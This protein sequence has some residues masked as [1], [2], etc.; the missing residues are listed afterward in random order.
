MG[1]LN[2][3]MKALV[4]SLGWFLWHAGGSG[5]HLVLGPSPPELSVVPRTGPRAEEG[6]LGP[7]TATGSQVPGH[8][9]AS[10][11]PLP[12]SGWALSASCVPDIV[13]W[14]TAAVPSSGE[15]GAPLC[16]SFP[17]PWPR[18]ILQDKVALGSPPAG[19]SPAAPLRQATLLP[20]TFLVHAGVLSSATRSMEAT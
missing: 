2:L 4:Q 13:G 12:F 11:S 18:L 1:R 19:T 15:P 3:E 20:A 6:F 8:H 5:G 17:L 7:T 9:Q 16:V 14:A 10:Q